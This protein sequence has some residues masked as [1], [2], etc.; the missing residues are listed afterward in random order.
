M[1]FVKTYVGLLGLLSYANAL[2]QFTPEEAEELTFIDEYHS[3]PDS[4]E[5]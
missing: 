5:K 3:S 1:N 2:K 4:V